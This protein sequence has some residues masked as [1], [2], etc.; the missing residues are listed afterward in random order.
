MS[1]P[2]NPYIA[3]PA[4]RGEKGFFGRQ[5]VLDWVAKGLRNPAT[6][7]LVLFGQ[8]R[9]GKTSLLLRLQRTLPADAFL[10]VYFDLHSKAKHPL[11]QVL[12]AMATRAAS[13]AGM[14]RPKSDLFDDEGLLFQ[15]AFLPRLYQMLG[16]HRRPVFILDEF[17]A[18]DS[19]QWL[20]LSQA[21]A[22]NSLF[23][24]IQDLMT[25]DPRP[26]FVFAVGRQAEDL[27]LSHGAVFKSSSVKKIWVLDRESAKAL[28]RQAEADG[29]LHFT[30][31]AVARILSLTSNHPFLT[32]LLCQRLWDRAYRGN[33][34]VPPSVDTPDVD[35][36]IPD[37]LEA[38]ELALAWIWN[39]M[40]PAERIY[41]AALAKIADE[42]QT[43]SED[44]VIQVLAEHADRL[45]TRE[46]ELAPRD[47]VNRQVLERAG[48]RQYRFAVELFRYW[49]RDNKP[50]HEVKDELDRLE[51]SAERLFSIGQESFYQRRWR[52]AVE[53]FQLALERNPRHFRARVH[54]GEALLEQG[55]TDKAVAELE[56]AYEMDRKAAHLPLVRALIAQARARQEDSDKDS[57]LAACQRALQISPNEPQVQE[58]Q[59]TIWQTE[60]DRLYR[61]GM[62][63]FRRKMWREAQIALEEVIRLSPDYC[64]GDAAAKLEIVRERLAQS[65]LIIEVLR[66]PLWQGIGAVLIIAIAAVFAFPFTKQIIRGLVPTP[67][68]VPPAICNG[69]F[70]DKFKCWQH[71]GELDQEVKCDD[72]QCYAVLG[73]P[74]YPCYGG[75]PVGEAWI[76]Q[77]F[78]VPQVVSPTLSLRYRVFSYDLDLLGYDYFQVA[79]NGELLPDRYGN[80]EWLEPSCSRAV[81]D[82]DWQTLTLNLSSYRGK[83]I[84]VS[85][86]NFNGTQSYHNTWTYVDEVRIELGH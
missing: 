58:L 51:P 67:V 69:D 59:A 4:L 71:G 35:A 14:E 28:V 73:N 8:R 86:H 42:G 64:D 11:G 41:T 63:H 12:A 56:R 7:V 80:S 40:G 30:D 83:T 10:T 79:I 31:Q 32:Q 66:N 84:E 15:S 37:A 26:A 82:S 18:I 53:L 68:S 33:P 29:T 38:G 85:F 60:L 57:A 52:D 27:F 46:V 70:D 75:V 13:Q 3:G 65:N 39:G 78:E 20:D 9:I 77:T 24:F 23:P 62:K 49:V 48:E 54:L 61:K 19:S 50:L 44:H 17:E 45:R 47:L 2:I 36:A 55:Q 21:A 34:A 1:R 74:D 6:N 76:K 72:P 81:W 43:I 16:G 5:E 25:T 22:A